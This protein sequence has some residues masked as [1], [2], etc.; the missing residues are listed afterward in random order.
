[1]CHS[2]RTS[3]RIYNTDIR[4]S[5]QVSQRRQWRCSGAFFF[6]LNRFIY[7]S[8]VLIC[9]L[10]AGDNDNNDNSNEDNGDDEDV[11]RAEFKM[12]LI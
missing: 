9:W 7:S 8:S 3:E 4:A 5:V 6:T 10:V 1:M 11:H 12:N 2:L